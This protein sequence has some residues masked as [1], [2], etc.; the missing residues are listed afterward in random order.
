MACDIIAIYD[1]ILNDNPTMDTR[2]ANEVINRL[3]QSQEVKGSTTNSDYKSTSN[4]N[5]YTI[6][7]GT[8]EFTK[9]FNDH[10]KVDVESGVLAD[11]LRFVT[12]SRAVVS[13]MS[14]H[15]SK[16]LPDFEQKVEESISNDG[17]RGYNNLSTDTLS[18]MYDDK[19]LTS[20][21]SEVLLHETLHTMAKDVTKTNVDMFKDLETIREA[22]K[23]KLESSIF[24]NQ[25]RIV[26]GRTEFTDAEK[27]SAE[28]KLDYIM[29]AD[30]EE[31]YA[32]AMSNQSLYNALNA[33]NVKELAENSPEVASVFNKKSS[34]KTLGEILMFLLESLFGIT[35][36]LTG[37][38]T[39]ATIDNLLTSQ[40][41]SIAEYQAKMITSANNGLFSDTITSLPY[42]GFPAK[43]ANTTFSTYESVAEVFDKK[44]GIPVTGKLKEGLQK[45]FSIAA[46][47]NRKLVNA[48]PVVVAMD[49]LNKLDTAKAIVQSGVGQAIKREIFTD[50]ANGSYR[51]FYEQIRKAAH[52]VDSVVSDL[53]DT[54]SSDIKGSSL[55]GVDSVESTKLLTDRLVNTGVFKHTKAVI[56]EL[57]KHG[58]LDSKISELES[59]VN[60]RLSADQLA[61]ID[62]LEKYSVTG[63]SAI[64]NQ[65]TSVQNI[66]NNMFQ[67]HKVRVPNKFKYKEFREIH[68]DIDLLMSLR[69]A[70]KEGA[71]DALINLDQKELIEIIELSGVYNKEYK[72]VQEITL[73][74]DDYANYTTVS[75]NYIEPDNEGIKNKISLVPIE[76][77]EDNKDR[78]GL[79]SFANTMRSD[80]KPI[81]INGKVFVKVVRKVNDVGFEEQAIKLTNIDSKGI[82]V[83][84]HLYNELAKEIELDESLTKEDKTKKVRVI[85]EVI[86]SLIKH[87][88][89]GKI[90][91]K[92]FLQ[93]GNVNTIPSYNEA[94][95]IVDYI[96]PYS[97]KEYRDDLEASTDIMNT[98]PHTISRMRSIKKADNNNKQVV[99]HL[100]SFAK[101]N[102][103]KLDKNDNE[104]VQFITISSTSSNPNA[105]AAWDL[106]PNSLKTYI[107]KERKLGSL[108]VPIDML[109]QIFGARDPSIVNLQFGGKNVFN[110]ITTRDLVSN[111]ESIVKEIFSKTKSVLILLNSDILIGNLISNSGVAAAEGI[112]RFEYF[113]E[114]MTQWRLLN[115]YHD[116]KDKLN[117]LEFEE[118]KGK[119]V[120]GA[121]VVARQRLMQHPVHQLVED[122]Q[123]TPLIDDADTGTDNGIL[124][125]MYRDKISLFKGKKSGD[126]GAE[127]QRELLNLKDKIKDKHPEYTEV[128]VEIEAEDA[129]QKGKLPNVVGK[130]IDTLFVNK[131]TPI[132]TAFNKFTLYGDTITRQMILNKRNK[133][134]IE[135][136]GSPLQGSEL[137]STLNELDAKLVN[138]TYLQNKYLSW[139]DKVAGVHFLK[140][141]LRSPKGYLTT[142]KREPFAVIG[143]QTL[144]YG[145]GIDV[146]DPVDGFIRNPIDNVSNRI[147]DPL[148][149]LVDALTPNLFVPISTLDQN[150]FFKFY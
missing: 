62:A 70:K 108:E 95:Q 33:V 128:E 149:K 99:D 114:F 86:D 111:A 63:E 20:S 45:M 61:H 16:Y 22:L 93:L 3:V 97:K 11:D 119:N 84:S 14:Q 85:N 43:V 131:G 9:A 110:N 73:N 106:L 57:S 92:S 116:I 91:S 37:V 98:L 112:S 58:N 109:D 94:G 89:Q 69:I 26:E 42:I 39:D 150:S 80:G 1:E 50:T 138:Y 148:E 96:L 51:K 30:I 34:P 13:F 15:F 137:R 130:V 129:L 88:S 18:I 83:R 79:F 117:K 67:Y 36:N 82:S 75:F 10:Y 135:S 144:Q 46:E 60:H 28:D 123:F 146:A 145:T 142:F 5:K 143:Q 53:K 81:I 41:H 72:S 8:D 54:I 125:G 35:P 66:L 102:K 126:G 121:I 120:A 17:T 101:A 47:Q 59:K 107:Q 24:L 27:K 90:S 113:K 44:I 104:I 2:Q 56:S 133:D 141:M 136:T 25:I 12:H 124:S 55:Y 40:I 100:I 122:G 140:Y 21:K 49:R 115:Q 48:S 78:T 68:D 132:Q 103:G 74:A 29:N 64:L 76:D 7:L 147:S 65:Q 38:P 71:V 127:Y 52:L 6:R 139:L 19:D 105:K 31:F 77:Y 134:S 87:Q 32:Y 118:S 23:D 4:L